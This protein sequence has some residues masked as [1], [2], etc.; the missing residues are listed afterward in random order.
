MLTAEHTVQSRRGES[1]S[2]VVV[3]LILVSGV[4]LSH[5][6]WCLQ[7]EVLQ[8]PSLHSYIW[9]PACQLLGKARGLEGNP[10][11]H[12]VFLDPLFIFLPY[13]YLS[14]CGHLQAQ[15]FFISVSSQE[16]FLPQPLWS[17][18]HPDL[19][20]EDSPAQSLIISILQN[21][22]DVFP[23]S[24]HSSSQKNSTQFSIPSL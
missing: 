1:D 19:W 16:I 5:P 20:N 24:S 22:K 11:Q 17:V 2:S 8:S 3:S 14:F 18:L 15:I 23:F 12:A 6:R 4:L 21:P 10:T 9:L 13:F 7:A